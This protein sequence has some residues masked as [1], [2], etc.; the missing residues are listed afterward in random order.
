MKPT[1]HKFNGVRYKIKWRKP[2]KKGWIGSCKAPW[3]KKPEIRISP[4]LKG[5][6]KLRVLID[7]SIHASY[8]LL[9]NDLVRGMSSSISGFLWKC[10]VRFKK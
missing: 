2:P 7:E 10:G 9:D 6:K 3:T 1:K 8:W 4:R 5:K